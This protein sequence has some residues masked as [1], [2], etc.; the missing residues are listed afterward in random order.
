MAKKSEEILAELQKQKEDIEILLSSL[1]EAYSE[2]GI[3]EKHY[4]EVKTKNQK[5][6]KEIE[7]KIKRIEKKVKPKEEKKPKTVGEMI[8]AE[9]GPVPVSEPVEGEIPVEAP[10]E[11]PRP[12]PEKPMPGVAKPG[13]ERFTSEDIKSMLSRFIKEI[14]PGGLQVLPRVEKMQIKLEK[15]GAFLDAMKEEKASGDE[16]I[17]RL[18][19]EIGEIR[20][21]VG[22]LDRK[23]SQQEI[24][25]SDINTA[26]A[27]LKPER[28]VNVLRKG[29]AQLKMHDAKIR[30]FED[31]T[32]LL[33]KRIT[34]IEAVL[35][36]I[37]SLE[38]IA[39]FGRDIARRLVEIENREKRIGRISDKIDS[40]FME[41]NKRLDEFVLYRAKQDTLDE[42]SREMMKAID[43]INTK[44]EKYAEKE[45][46]DI[47]RD[48]LEARISGIG[49]PSTVSKEVMK[50]QQQQREIE[51]LL[52]ILGE[53]FRKGKIKKEEYEKAKKVNTE[54]LEDI[55]KKIQEQ[56]QAPEELEGQPA[57]EPMEEEPTEEKPEVAETEVKEEK[58][59]GEK[60]VEE[61]P[62]KKPVEKKPAKTSKEEMIEDLEESYKKGEISKEAY[63]RTKK[64]LKGGK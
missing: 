57:P 22:A 36:K 14:K 18:T 48:T 56:S 45:D 31:M 54:R 35:K 11:M 42:L 20:S 55:K 52:D 58:G 10:A 26:I 15:M 28:F 50:L 21:S 9:Q 53:Q 5:R 59:A 7:R 8:E 37:G 6:L 47:L 44:I 38:K 29:D 34:Q 64:I 27:D 51:E 1:E 23:I 19:E 33:V 17:R 16:T 32:P 2:A 24:I 30:R 12:V 61:K 41:L 4:K 25:V 63:E 46:M 43:D 62:E 60:P 39:D 13:E 3:S 40:I 49:M